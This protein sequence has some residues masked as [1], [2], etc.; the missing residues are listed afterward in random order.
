[1]KEEKN[2][3]NIIKY[4][5]LFY[6]IFVIIATMI[7]DKSPSSY[8]DYYTEEDYSS[9]DNGVFK[10]IASSENQVFED[11]LRRF[12]N[13]KGYDISI[14]YSGTL[15]I[16]NRLNA[17]ESFD[18]AWVSNSI[19]LYMADSKVKIKDSQSTSIIPVVFAVKKSKAEELGFMNKNLKTAD[20]VNAISEGKLKFNMSNPTT[21]DSGASAYLGLLYTL[22]GNPEV[23]T[24]EILEKDEL[25]SSLRNFFTGLARS[26]GSEEFL[27]ELFINGDYEAVFTYESSIIEIN[28]KLEAYGKEPLYA[29]Y[30]TDGVSISD[31]PFAYID[32]GIDSKKEIFQDFQDYLLSK[33]G[34]ALLQTKGRRTW[35]GGINTE[36]DKSV[37]NPNWGIDTT[38]YITP[39]KFPSTT[40][41]KYALKLYQE[42]LRKPVHVVFCLDYSGSMSGDGEEELEKAM[43]YILSDEAA[44][45]YI[46][47][48]DKD[49]I[50][51]IP[52]A[53]EANSY[54]STK[55]GFSREMLLD[56]IISWH[57]NGTTALFPAAI[58]ALS[59]V[60]DTDMNEYAVSIVLM[61]DG[62]S[63]VG[64][65]TDLQ[66]VYN[67]IGKDIPIYS[68]TFGFPNERDLE[69]I[70]ELT[71]GKVFDGKT[72][73]VQAFKEVRGYN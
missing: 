55:L 29:L 23:L 7:P 18:A 51:V 26:S 69:N 53:T 43:K 70:A 63:N 64:T 16:M 45:D 42:E 13:K 22:A 28:K 19:W 8:N 17:G 65:I 50:E 48:S 25:K 39:V 3:G 41:I 35:F 32:R 38:K 62:Q 37:F 1:M 60:K 57:A 30:P 33:E 12:A 72:G 20:L 9:F 46:Q 11:D 56:T 5:V 21:T 71:N 10:I 54:I 49:I 52:F 61:T 34:Q 36:A 47:F 66:T 40:V 58:G 59:L 73:L 4:A 67:R 14:E 31:S 15:D 2:V 6:I 27:E 68:I 44:R 24:T